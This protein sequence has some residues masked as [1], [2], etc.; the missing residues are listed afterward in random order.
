M[1]NNQ[2]KRRQNSFNHNFVGQMA[3]RFYYHS[4]PE[5]CGDDGDD[6]LYYSKALRDECFLVHQA[7]GQIPPY[8]QIKNFVVEFK[9]N[10]EILGNIGAI[11]FKDGCVLED[12]SPSLC[13]DQEFVLRKLRDPVN[14]KFISVRLREDKSF[15]ETWS[16]KTI[17]WVLRVNGLSTRKVLLGQKETPLSI[18]PIL[19]SHMGAGDPLIPDMNRVGM[20]WWCISLF[21]NFEHV[22]GKKT[23]T[24]EINQSG[25]WFVLSK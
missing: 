8:D 4:I 14:Y 19:I 24:A 12:A 15:R 3:D 18:L 5:F 20:F 10:K 9:D 22:N 21:L 11:A 17:D 25:D 16:L 23:A 1:P 2:N 13:D 7:D 6:P